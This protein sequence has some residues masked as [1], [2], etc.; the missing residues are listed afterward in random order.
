MERY[1]MRGYSRWATCL[2]AAVFSLSGGVTSLVAQQRG[3]LQG[4]VT[5]A[6]TLE[7]LAGAQVQVVG[8]A[9]GA[10]TNQSGRFQIDGVA[11]GSQ[12]IRIVYLGYRTETRQVDVPAGGVVQVE[13][14]LTGTAIA[15][16]E[17]VVTGTGAPTER[18]RLGQTISAVSGDEL[19]LAPITTLGQALQG[20]VPGITGGLGNRETGQ[21]DRILLRGAASLSQRNEPL[22]YVDGIRINNTMNQTAGVRADRLSELNPADIERIEVIRGAAAATLF[23]TEASSGVIQIFT[24]RGQAGSPVYTFQVDQHLIQMP[25]SKFPLNAGYDAATRRIVTDKPSEVWVDLGHQ[26][27]YNASVRGGT[28]GAR[29][30]ASL[31]LLHEDGPL[32]NN[33]LLNGALRTNLD[34]QHTDRLATSVDVS[35]IRSDLEA[36]RP[37][38]SSIVSEMVLANPAKATELRPHGEQDFTV[39]GSLKDRDREKTTQILLAS[40]VTYDLTETLR[41]QAKLGYHDVTAKRVRMRPEGEVLDLSGIRQVWNRGSNATT[42]DASLA[43]NADVTDRLQSSFVVGG[44]SFWESR[45]EEEASVEDFAA[46]SLQTLR[47]GSR[48]TGVDEFKEQV[49]NAGVFVQE[50]I[51]L[52]NRLFFTV[53]VRMDGNSAFGEDFGFESYPKAGVSW[54]VSD[55]DFFNVPGVSELRVRGAV[56]SAGLQPGAFDALRT[57]QPTSFVGGPS[58]APLNLGNPTLKP[59]RSTEREIGIEAGLFGGRVGLE[60]VYFDQ[61]TTDALLPASPS[62]S[63][64]F[65]SSQLINLGRLSSSGWELSSTFRAVERPGFGWEVNAAFTHTDQVVED[66]GG[67]AD[68]R[69]QGRRRW[70]WIAE[71]YRPGAVLAPAQNPN[72]PYRL[73]VPI[74]RLTKLGQILPNMLKTATGQDSLVYMGNALPTWTVDFG[75]TFRLGENITLRA[76]FTGAGGN[77]IISNETEVLRT[78][79]SQNMTVARAQQILADPNATLADK[80]WILENYGKRHPNV[81]SSFMEKGDYLRFGELS[82]TYQLPD[83]MAGSLG[84]GRTTISLGGRNL[85]VW[86]GYSGMIDPGSAPTGGAGN[87]VFLQNIDYIT[88]PSTRRFTLSVQTTL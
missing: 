85:H 54:V 37:S 50:Q 55:H 53:G 21:A 9:T 39:A 28:P 78:A 42:V 38:W 8:T 87:S 86:T 75:S 47:G 16:D 4:L 81:V 23:G 45:L 35:L 1:C 76:L 46:P 25:Q 57:W 14:A 26:Q 77:Y 3:T 63:T 79:T 33:T 48:I 12:E 31:R 11:A 65:T 62:P 69:I 30:F 51:G 32:P 34:F 70:S 74:D 40:T 29:Y 80:Q 83:R 88:A 41:A 13:I 64:G 10:L 56:G 6:S 36:P 60:V 68:F 52:D 66:M 58:V 7:P 43:W 20:R 72:N 24:R 73:T 67:V 49:I 61:T 19:A 84:L 15:L 18:R 27:N 44:Q 2:A 5:D 82:L 17:V 59:E 71:G 22:I